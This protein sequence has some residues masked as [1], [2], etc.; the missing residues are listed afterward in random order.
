MCFLT[1]WA[2][3]AD[4]QMVCHK[5]LRSSNQAG[6]GYSPVADLGPSPVLGL[7]LVFTGRLIAIWQIL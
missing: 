1:T 5:Q 2:G 6:H 4:V 7:S 3:S